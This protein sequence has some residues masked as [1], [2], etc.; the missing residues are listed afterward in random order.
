MQLDD[1]SYFCDNSV[2]NI[3]MK[4]YVCSEMNQLFMRTS[5][6]QQH[7]DRPTDEQTKTVECVYEQLFALTT[8]SS[9]YAGAVI[10]VCFYCP[11]VIKW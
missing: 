2:S 6:A 3:N 1:G 5:S 7:T 9:G 4:Q 8:D 10:R 11:L